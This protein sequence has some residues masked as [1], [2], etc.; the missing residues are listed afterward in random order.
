MSFEGSNLGDFGLSVG[1]SLP[2]LS[3]WNWLSWSWIGS[4]CFVGFVKLRF[5]GLSSVRLVFCEN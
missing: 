1:S 4:S 3:L 5:G 2:S